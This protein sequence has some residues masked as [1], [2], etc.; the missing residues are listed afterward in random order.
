VVRASL[1]LG[2]SRRPVTVAAVAMVINVIGDLTLGLAWGVSGLAASTTLSLLLAATANA[3]LLRRCHR[4][5]DILPL[6]GMLG[7]VL[8]AGGCAAAAAGAA[9]RLLPVEAGAVGALVAPAA[10]GVVLPGVFAAALFA[11]RGPETVVLRDAARL[12]TRR[13]R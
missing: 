12:L 11:L 8:A 1:A 13:R 9:V 5:V 2:D 10:I 6:A 4:L 3:W 7:R